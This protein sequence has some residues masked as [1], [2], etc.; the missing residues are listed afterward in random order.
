MALPVRLTVY[1]GEAGVRVGSAA[2]WCVVVATLTGLA[3]RAAVSGAIA[4]TTAATIAIFVLN[5]NSR[6]CEGLG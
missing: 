1:D 4:A 3:A 5:M 6:G 2:A